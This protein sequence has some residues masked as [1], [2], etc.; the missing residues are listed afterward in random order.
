MEDGGF[1]RIRAE[2]GDPKSINPNA[3][4]NP[5]RNNDFIFPRRK[6]IFVMK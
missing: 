4:T 2:D 5:T 3:E 6:I 1:G